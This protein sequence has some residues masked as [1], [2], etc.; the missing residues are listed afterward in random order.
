MF[1]QTKKRIGMIREIASSSISIAPLNEG[2]HYSLDFF[3]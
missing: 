2:N 1:V 3:A